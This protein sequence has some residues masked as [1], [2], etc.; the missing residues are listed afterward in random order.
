MS[1]KFQRRSDDRKNLR[2]LRSF[3]KLCNSQDDPEKLAIDW[4]TVEAIVQPIEFSPK[5]DAIALSKFP[6][7]IRDTD[8]IQNKLPEA[9]GC[10]CR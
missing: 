5:W 10:F 4:K 7:Q 2:S 3:A 1:E 6:G 9:S 8:K